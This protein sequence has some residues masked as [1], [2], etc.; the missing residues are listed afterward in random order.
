MRW[1]AYREGEWCRV[2][3]LVPVRV[4]DTWIWLEHF[5]YR[6]GYLGRWSQE[7]SLVRPTE[8]GQ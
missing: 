3:A 4:D 7:R 5:W 6:E 8:E 2:F 1:K